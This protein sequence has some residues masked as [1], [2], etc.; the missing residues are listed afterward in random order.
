MQLTRDDLLEAFRHHP[1]IGEQKAA[2]AQSAQAQRWS[3]Q[4]QAGVEVAPAETLAALAEANQ[5]YEARFG[6]I[7]LICATGKTS[8][9]MLALL[10]TRLHNDAE[11]ELRIAAVEQQK[12]TRI[13]LEK[14]LEQ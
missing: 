10:R 12:I 14:L 1:R 4:E 5:A 11:Q 13:R 3:K 9:E 6:Y 8:E 2:E 7:F